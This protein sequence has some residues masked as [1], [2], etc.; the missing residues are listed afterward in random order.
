MTAQR[1]W[2]EVLPLIGM[3]RT[4]NMPGCITTIP[5][6]CNIGVGRTLSRS[7]LVFAIGSLVCTVAGDVSTIEKELARRF[8]ELAS[9][10]Y[11][12]ALIHDAAVSSRTA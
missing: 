5:A 4:P 2:E 7:S 8:P 3:Q 6:G 12:S 11:G 1:D 9:K 10:S